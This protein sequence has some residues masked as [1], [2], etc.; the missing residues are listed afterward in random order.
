LSIDRNLLQVK[1]FTFQQTKHTNS[2]K[3]TPG[4]CCPHQNRDGNNINTQTNTK[5][6]RTV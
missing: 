3:T 5:S 4:T 1:S 6:W 2:V